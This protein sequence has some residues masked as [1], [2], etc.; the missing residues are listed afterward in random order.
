MMSTPFDGT[1]GGTGTKTSSSPPSI[2]V[3]SGVASGGT[4]PSTSGDGPPSSSRPPSGWDGGGCG[5][6]GKEQSSS[7]HSTRLET[8]FPPAVH[9]S[10]S[11]H[12]VPRQSRRSRMGSRRDACEANENDRVAKMQFVG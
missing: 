12:F 11:A 3:L 5:S 1:Q 10:P 7:E 8:H 2:T 4:S 6:S 9:V